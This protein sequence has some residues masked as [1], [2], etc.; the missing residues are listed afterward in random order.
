MT[1]GRPKIS[2]L[3]L[4]L[5]NAIRRRRVL[6][7]YTQQQMADV[8]GVTYQQA[9]K[10]ETSINR[11]SFGRLVHIAA[12]LDMTV[13]ELADAAVS[14]EPTRKPHDIAWANDAVFLAA[15]PPAARRALITAA[16]AL[17]EQS[18]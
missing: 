17:M 7:G 10:Y 6:L 4:A 5:A 3:D 18:E 12:A 9:H 13:A 15:M 14:G 1:V 2:D 11:V 8:I 16:K